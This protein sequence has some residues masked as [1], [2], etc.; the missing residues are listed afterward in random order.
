M[1]GLVDRIGSTRSRRSLACSGHDPCFGELADHVAIAGR[2]PTALRRG[3]RA[4]IDA[5][6]LRISRQAA[7]CAVLLRS[8]RASA[9]RSPTPPFGHRLDALFQI[10]VVE[11]LRIKAD[12]S[13]AQRADFCVAAF[14]VGDADEMLGQ[15]MLGTQ[16]REKFWLVSIVRISASC[17]T[18]LSRPSELH[19]IARG[20]STR[21]FALDEV[22]GYARKA[23][24]FLRSGFD[25]AARASGVRRIDQHLRTAQCIDVLV[26][27]VDPHRFRMMEAMAAEIIGWL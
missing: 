19:R 26:G 4:R 15:T 2:L 12:G 3:A 24:G 17:G 22:V 14:D 25:F 13:R 1:Y 11:E 23:I 9:D 10:L 21:R 7:T 6:F 27:L 18:L 8:F 5:N 20:H 16:N